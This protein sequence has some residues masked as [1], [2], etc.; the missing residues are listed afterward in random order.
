MTESIS[1]LLFFFKPGGETTSNVNI[2]KILNINYPGGSCLM[3]VSEYNQLSILAAATTE[4]PMKSFTVTAMI[5]AACLLSGCIPLLV[6]GAAAG[7]TYAYVAG[8][9]QVTEE[10]P[11]DVLWLA[12]EEALRELEL[13]VVSKDKDGL[14]GAIRAR[15]SEDKAITVRLEKKA[16]SV[17]TI[18]IRVGV[19]GDEQY[20]R[21][22]LQKI[23]QQ[24]PYGNWY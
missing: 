24:T 8:E 23:R 7:G 3:N 10:V 16:P 9:M 11:L 1:R 22:I 12:S 2:F 15:G 17:T 5:I 20:S 18:R 6:G 19:F 13:T 4:Q 21:L 14:S